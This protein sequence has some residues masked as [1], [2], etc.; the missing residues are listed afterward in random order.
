M[1]TLNLIY[2][3]T[4]STSYE[5]LTVKI[6]FPVQYSRTTVFEAVSLLVAHYYP[7]ALTRMA[8]T[9][10]G[11]WSSEYSGNPCSRCQVLPIQHENGLKAPPLSLN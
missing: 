4:V 10:Q 11:G 9:C 8:E 3:V 7:S 1:I 2:S 5:A 6:Y